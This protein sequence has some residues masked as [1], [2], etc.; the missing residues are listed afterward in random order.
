M[1]LL[2]GCKTKLITETES[3]G[4]NEEIKQVSPTITPTDNLIESTSTP[5]QTETLTPT[6]TAIST[7]TRED[8]KWI[9]RN[10]PLGKSSCEFPCFLGIQPG[11][12]EFGSVIDIINFNGYQFF[13]VR[14]TE[15]E[16]NISDVYWEFDV[17]IS[18][19]RD[20]RN[21]LVQNLTL[22]ILDSTDKN[23]ETFKEEL[24]LYSPERMIAHYG[25][26]D[27]LSIVIPEQMWTGKNEKY[28]YLIIFYD[29]LGL[30]ID[31][32]G[33][34]YND[35][36]VQE[37]CPTWTGLD[38][39]FSLGINETQSGLPLTVIPNMLAHSSQFP[40]QE[41]TTM[42]YFGMTPEEFVIKHI[43]SSETSCIM[44]NYE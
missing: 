13:D 4:T 8:M 20:P 11:E 33:T 3:I 44:L 38:A 21:G 42:E 28:Y 22:F 32:K 1:F 10:A 31:Y 15:S 29:Q 9:I 36:Y 34:G 2:F 17:H 43:F 24:I 6:E 5:T 18:T 41:Y 35:E 39:S 19:K 37:I 23:K 27:R 14:E 12:T 26:P 7:Y 30:R 25:M 40:E 16:I